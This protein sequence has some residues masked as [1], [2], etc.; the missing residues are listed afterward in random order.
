MLHGRFC[1]PWRTLMCLRRACERYAR[2]SWFRKMTMKHICSSGKCP[3]GTLGE[4]GQYLFLYHRL[5]ER[6]LVCEVAEDGVGVRL[7]DREWRDDLVCQIQ[8]ITVGFFTKH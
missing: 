8:D 6:A 3:W 1:L 7:R 2:A 4:N 5:Q